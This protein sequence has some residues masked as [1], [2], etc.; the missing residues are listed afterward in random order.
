MSATIARPLDAERRTGNVPAATRPLCSLTVD[1]EDWYQSSV[2]QDA[3]ITERVLRNTD[4]LAS[5]LDECGVKATFFVQG[6]VAEKYPLLVRELL[7]AGHEIQSH[8]HT[9]RP[10]HGMDRNGLRREL[11]RA[12][13]TVEDACGVKVTAF[14]A[15]DFSILRRNVWALEV[16]AEMGFELDSSIF[17]IAMKRYGIDSWPLVPHRVPLANGMEILE[18]PVAVWTAL[19]KRVPVSGGGYFRVLPQAV[20]EHT[21]RSIVA[22]GR[23]AIVYC[24]PY[25]FNPRELDDYADRVPLAF[26]LY[27]G[28]G[29]ASFAGRV[30]HL[31]RTL[32]FGRLDQV[33]RTW[34]RGVVPGQTPVARPCAVTEVGS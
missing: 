1:L 10:L 29:R 3:P 4:R 13:K 22:A 30:R 34:E 17:P 19:G 28:M 6:M 20:L 27:Q 11:D 14:R 7:A 2:D 31:L 15:P 5:L 9:H 8:G 24:H 12:R 18:V 33:I 23:P 26:R 32:P 25:E 16:L 21:L